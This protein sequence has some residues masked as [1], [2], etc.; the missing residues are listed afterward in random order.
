MKY[1]SQDENYINAECANCKRVLKILKPS[2]SVTDFGYKIKN[3][4]QCPCNAI[5][6]VILREKPPVSSITTNSKQQPSANKNNNTWL[7]ILV[8][9]GL[10]LV[11]WFMSRTKSSTSSSSASSNNADTSWFTGGTLHKSTIKEWGQATYSN[12]LATS[13][14]FI[15]ATQN[16]D[17]GNLNKFKEMSTEL[18]KCISIAASGGDVDNEKVTFLSSICTVQLFPK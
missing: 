10:C 8:I 9:V 6:D 5:S 14:D 11:S 4:V 3:P 12:R 15:A 18:E 16:V 1:F 2:C 7:V 17:Y 13:A